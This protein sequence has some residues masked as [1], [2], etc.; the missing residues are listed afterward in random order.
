M[1]S[2]ISYLVALFVTP[3]Q[4]V[5]SRKYH[6]VAI[7]YGSYRFF[8]CFIHGKLSCAGSSA[9]ESV[10]PFGARRGHLPD[11]REIGQ[12]LIRLQPTWEK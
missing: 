12:A 11:R 10:L 9:C 4:P 1:E 5:V 6:H 3:S 8:N 7:Y 2:Y